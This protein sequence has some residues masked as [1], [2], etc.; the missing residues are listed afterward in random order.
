M[1]RALYHPTL[2]R[3]KR[4]ETINDG[5]IKDAGVVCKNIMKAAEEI[6]KERKYL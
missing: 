3:F 5:L 1:T 6:Q 4:N 2:I